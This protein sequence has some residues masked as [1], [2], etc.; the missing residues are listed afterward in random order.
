M[1]RFILLIML[2]PLFVACYT[3]Q[4]KSNL[5]TECRNLTNQKS[6]LQSQISYMRNE[7]AELE[8][9]MN[10]YRSGRDVT[11]IVRFEIKQTTMTLDIMEHMKNDMNAVQIEIPVT[12]EFYNKVYVGQDISN[13]TKM[14]SLMMDGDFSTLHV[15]VI[16]KRVE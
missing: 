7:V 9:K 2:L 10:A 15:K 13:T 5:Q 16:N 8:T 1:K 11:Y 4:D 6:S 12:K 14:G 3:E